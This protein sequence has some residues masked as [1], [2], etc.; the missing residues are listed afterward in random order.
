MIKEVFAQSAAW[1]Y[2]AWVVCIVGVGSMLPQLLKIILTRKVDDLSPLAFGIVYVSQLV[3]C[4]D[5]YFRR[6]RMLMVCM[7]SGSQITLAIIILYYLWRTA[8]A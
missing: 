7:G 1:K 8:G 6:N 3:Y 4:V 2:F 5:G